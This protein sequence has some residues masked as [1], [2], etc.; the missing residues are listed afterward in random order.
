MTGDADFGWRLD[1]AFAKFGHLCVGID[2]HPYLFARWGYDDTPRS[3]D[4]FS[5]R[6]LDACVDR[7][8]IIKP[9][10]A[11]FERWGAAGYRALE[12][13]IRRARQADILVI[14]DAK[15]GDIGS[16]M[17]AYAQ[18]WLSPGT[19]LESDALTVSPYLGLGALDE[20][21]DLARSQS[22]GVFV[23]AATSNPEALGTQTSVVTNGVEAG[24]PLAHSIVS[25]VHAANEASR[26]VSGG[27]VI[28]ATVSLR[29]FGIEPDEF[30]GLPV[31]APGFGFQGADPRDAR[32]LFGALTNRLIVTETRSILESGPEEI[33]ETLS[34]RAAIVAEALA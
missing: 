16:T 5:K 2:P 15:R 11:F 13:V 28:G 24:L 29:D 22:K 20:T 9:Q 19:P 21:M 10:V 27:V 17:Q 3:L 33:R 34:Q 30:P 1:A 4:E 14:A 32:R 18:S 25:R 26:Q 8:G 7:V 31:L 12:E 23:L 6:V